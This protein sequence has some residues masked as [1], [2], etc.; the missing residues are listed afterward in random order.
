M[1]VYNLQVGDTGDLV[2]T[3]QEKLKI[4]GFYNAVVTGVFGVSTEV[5]VLAFQKE[6]V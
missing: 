6:F 4:L 2:K 1:D 3:L 5:G